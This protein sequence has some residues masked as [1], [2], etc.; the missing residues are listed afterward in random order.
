MWRPLRV[1]SDGVTFEFRYDPRWKYSLWLP[2]NPVSIQLG[3]TKFDA[4]LASRGDLDRLK[5]LG[6]DLSL[7]PM[8]EERVIAGV[9]ELYPPA[10]KMHEMLPYDQAEVRKMRFKQTGSFTARWGRQ[11]DGTHL[12]VRHDIRVAADGVGVE[13]VGEPPPITL[14]IE[15]PDEGHAPAMELTPEQFDR[16]IGAKGDI[17]VVR[18]V[19]SERPSETQGD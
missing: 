14:H 16:I 17:A 9:R 13:L 6:I 5:P 18:Q 3:Q 11:R 10:G 7:A 1:E 2:S 4:L 12:T 15:S 8:D 19:W